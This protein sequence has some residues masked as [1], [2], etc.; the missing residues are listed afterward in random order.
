[1]SFTAPEMIAAGFPATI[2]DY[3]KYMVE[4]VPLAWA[5][6]GA[7]LD[8]VHERLVRL[9]LAHPAKA[10]EALGAE[11]RA[12]EVRKRPGGV[13]VVVDT[14]DVVP[15]WRPRS[16]V[17]MAFASSA[18]AVMPGAVLQLCGRDEGVG[19]GELPPEFL[20]TLQRAYLIAAAWGRIEAQP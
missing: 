1:M 5:R 4:L 2:R 11:W 14:C 15:L 3:D 9:A 19:Y 13:E 6:S 7:G 10:G 16:F 12:V 17:P 20:T 18:L 8:I